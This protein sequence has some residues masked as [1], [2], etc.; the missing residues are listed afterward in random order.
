VI[1]PPLVTG[2]IVNRYKRFLAD[3]ELE[4]GRLVTAHCANTGSM[5]GCWEPGAPVQLSHSD[6]PRR[7][8]NW[9]LERV[10]MGGGWIGVNTARVNA[11]VAEGI[12]ANR[13]PM[14]AGYR[15]IRREPS[16]TVTGMPRSR[17]DLALEDGDRAPCMVEIKNATLL[18]HGVIQ[19]PDSVTRRGLKHLELLAA[20][21]DLG[22]RSCMVFALNRSESRVFN[23]AFDIDPDYSR[24]LIE[25]AASGVEVI[26]V[27]LE[28]LDQRIEAVE[29]WAWEVPDMPTA[30]AP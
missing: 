9:T 16:F 11:I 23:P 27:R 26:I 20:A 18:R 19:F 15:S 6:D 17:F 3:V 22:V 5:R 12:R 14:L 13:L 21:L 7:K 24:R 10:D 4:S 25:V 2:R 28:H 8:L 30:P 29:A 1:L